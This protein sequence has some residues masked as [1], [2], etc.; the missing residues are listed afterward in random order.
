MVRQYEREGYPPAQVLAV[1]LAGDGER[2]DVGPVAR[3]QV[4]GGG[5]EHLVAVEFEQLD[6]ARGAVAQ[7]RPA[8]SQRSTMRSNAG[9]TARMRA[10]SG[11]GSGTASSG[12]RSTANTSPT[13]RCAMSDDVPRDRDV[14]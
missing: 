11:S 7:A 3:D 4:R 8:I 10:V 12:A 9:T 13:A 1:L 14:P 6:G 5:G 2:A